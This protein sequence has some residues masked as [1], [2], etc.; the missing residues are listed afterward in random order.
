MNK[1]ALLALALASLGATTLSAQAAD[2]QVMTQN[3][4]VG[5]EIIGLVTNPDLNAAIVYALETRAAS[6]PAER[7]TA[8]ASLVKSRMPAL[9]GMQE[10]WDFGCVDANP[11]DSFGCE[12]PAIAGAFVQQLAATEQAL[13]GKFQRA[14]RVHNIN[15]TLPVVYHGEFMW[16]SV[17][18]QD[19]IFVRDDVPWQLIPFKQNGCPRPSPT[20]EGCNYSMVA[21]ATINVGGNPVPVNFE[22]GYVGVF[23][24]VDGVTYPFVNTHLETRLESSGTFGRIYQSGQAAEL[25]ATVGPLAKSGF[26]PIVVGDFNSDPR[27]VPFTLPPQLIGQLLQAGVPQAVIPYLGVPAYHLLTGAGFTNAWTLRP[28]TAKGQGAPVVGLSCCQNEYLDNH[29][30]AFYERIDHI[31]SFAKPTKVRDARVLGESIADKTPPQGLGVWP[32]DH[33]SVAATLQF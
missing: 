22:R 3:Q 12:H 13:S 30:S 28:G 10:V 24:T 6:L 7:V 8:L 32:S 14:A 19:V 23:A 27:D 2:V 26:N 18:D 17:L 16:V 21:S 20:S 29:R 4:Y 1:H 9:V 31:W 33:A 25:L 15:L 11:A 5:T